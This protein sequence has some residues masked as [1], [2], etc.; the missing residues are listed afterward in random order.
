MIKQ[1]YLSDKNKYFKHLLSHKN[2]YLS[3]FAAIIFLYVILINFFSEKTLITGAESYYY[4]SNLPS[5]NPWGI[6]VSLLPNNV[7][8]L[9]PPT[10]TI[11]SILLFIRIADNIK[12]PDRLT[13]IF[14]AFIIATP[15]FIYTATIISSYS[16]LIFLTLAGVV[17]LTESN[18]K[19]KFISPIFFLKIK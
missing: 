8:F 12:L 15:A 19:V 3:S 16:L 14:L 17:L 18:Q 2:L 9:I 13:F 7:L 5:F 4:L 10:L 1:N 6:I 11:I